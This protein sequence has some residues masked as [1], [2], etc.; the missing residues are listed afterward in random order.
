[1][2]L[3][4]LSDTLADLDSI[5]N[6]CLV[7][8]VSASSWS[9]AESIAATPVASENRPWRTRRPATL[10]LAASDFVKRRRPKFLTWLQRSRDRDRSMAFASTRSETIKAT[11]NAFRI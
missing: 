10:T 6:R 3:M 4:R 9:A 11:K 7:K 8:R 5:P 1:M 2:T